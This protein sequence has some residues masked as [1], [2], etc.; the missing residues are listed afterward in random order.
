VTCVQTDVTVN[1]KMRRISAFDAFLPKKTVN[2]RKNLSIC[3]RTIVLSLDLEDTGAL[4]AKGVFIQAE[5]SWIGL[6][7]KIRVG[8]TK[9]IIMAAGAIAT[10]QILLLR[11]VRDV[12]RCKE[13][14]WVSNSGIGDPKH[15]N[16][17][18]IDIVHELNG[19]GLGLQD[20]IAVPVVYKVPRNHT[21]YEL[22]HNPLLGIREFF[23]YIFTAKGL[24]L[25]AYVQ[26]ALFVRSGLL[27]PG[28][29]T[30]GNEQTLD[31][32]SSANIPDIEIQPIAYGATDRDHKDELAKG[33]GAAT[34][35]VQLLRPKSS[36]SVK[37]ANRNARDRP[38][39]ELGSFT[40]A[41][42]WTVLRKGLK[43]A[44]ALG[45][46]MKKEDYPCEPLDAPTGESDAELDAFIKLRA[47]TTFHYSSSC[48]MA[49]QEEGGVVDDELRV[50]GI[51]GLRIADAS[52]FPTIPACH[53][54]AP[55]VMIG[56]RCAGFILGTKAW[57]VHATHHLMQHSS[58]AILWF[59]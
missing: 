50:H 3:T 16:S 49:P 46:Q 21:I 42:D 38:K 44:L 8:A 48:R 1:E 43:L 20:H 10:P 56:E 58:L 18:G 36:G 33:E 27:T 4:K 28:S 24:F 30:A 11:S 53:L 17:V 13:L 39:C 31:A 59:I 54:Q 37:L 51:V 26:V 40:K 2:A 35:L 12:M 52:V 45:R 55:V 47:N 32:N 15:L 5:D 29:V 19:V 22:Q 9:E 7:T 6:K 25:S 34:L 23:K 57:R 14:C 41:E